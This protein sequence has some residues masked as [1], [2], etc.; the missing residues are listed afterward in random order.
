MIDV[1]GTLV[2]NR[3]DGMPSK[4][5]IEAINKASKIMKVGLATSRPMFLVDDILKMANFSGVSILQGGAQIIDTTSRKI[6]WEKGIHRE[7]IRMLGEAFKK[8]KIP[9]YIN[10]KE[11]DVVYTDSYE[12]HHPLQVFLIGTDAE[13]LKSI[14]DEVS[15]LSNLALYTVPAWEQGKT[16]VIITHALATKQH[17]IF[18]VAKLLNIDTKDIIGVGDGENDFPLLMAC[19]LKVAMGNAVDDLKAIADYIAPTVE[20]DGVADV[21]EK[22]IL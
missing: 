16:G 21:I 9:M 3:K 1:D 19:G 10:D 15:K 4:K 5:V 12:P 14:Q 11:G 17:G 2:P 13:S 6:L 8:A 20:E 18:E 7:D 22:F